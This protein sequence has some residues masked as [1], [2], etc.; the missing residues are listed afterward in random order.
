GNLTYRTS[1]IQAKTPDTF[2]EVSP[3]LAQARGIESGSLVRLTSRHG[4]LR[5][6]AVVTDRVHDGELY[7]PMNSTASPINLLTGSHNDPVTHTPAYKETAVNL[8]VL[9]KNGDSPLPRTNFRF[10][11]P[12]PQLGVKVDAKW[13]RPDYRF[14]GESLIQIKKSQIEK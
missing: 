9:D 12:T 6:R 11:H 1:G 10:G 4:S 7:M 13:R 2:V 3:E 5:V 8:Q 14:P